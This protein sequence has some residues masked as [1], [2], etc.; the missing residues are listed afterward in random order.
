MPGRSL[1]LTALANFPLIREGDDLARLILAG[2]DAGGLRLEDGDILILAQK[3]VS[4]SEG[5][6]VDLKGVEPSVRARAIAEKSQKDPRFVE[7]VLRESREVL[8]VRPGLL[9]VEHRL[10]FICANAGVDRSNIGA[11]DGEGERVLLLPEDP[12]ASCR[13]LRSRMKEEAGA[14][15]GVVINDSHGR[16]WR[17]GIVG[18]AIG[19]AGLPALE[20]LRGRMDLYDY[21]LQITQ[22]AAADELASAASLL[23]GQADEALPVVHARGFPYPMRESTMVELIRPRD[24]DAFR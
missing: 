23:M 1:R 17:N 4:K 14:E 6:L 9:V 24:Q 5:R 18:V 11:E 13:S 21:Q 12:D 22:V 20:D 3:I 7:M 16:A 10:G 8:R 15:V 2:L 19:V